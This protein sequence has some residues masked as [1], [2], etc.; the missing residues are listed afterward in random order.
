MARSRIARPRSTIA[1]SKTLRA[2]AI[3]SLMAFAGESLLTASA[4]GTHTRL[5]LFP[6]F[7]CLEHFCQRLLVHF[8]AVR[9]CPVRHEKSLVI[10]QRDDREIDL[11]FVAI[12]VF[13][14]P[15][16]VVDPAALESPGPGLF[17]ALVDDH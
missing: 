10:G 8:V 16:N 6:D 15:L 2:S 12:R 5:A 1:S 4:F 11:D 13:A 14:L 7:H 3:S 9:R 17:R